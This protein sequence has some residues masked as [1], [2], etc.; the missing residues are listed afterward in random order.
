MQKKKICTFLI[1]FSAKNYQ[2]LFFL[3]IRYISYWKEK[4]T[5]VKDLKEVCVVVKSNSAPEDKG[6]FFC[7]FF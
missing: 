1:N 6:C 3:F 7:L 4:F 5:T 2:V